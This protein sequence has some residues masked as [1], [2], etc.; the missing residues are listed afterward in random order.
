MKNSCVSASLFVLVITALTPLKAFSQGPPINT[1]TAIITGLEGAA[2]RSF[3]KSIKKSGDLPGG[4]TGRVTAIAVPLVV[5]YE[6]FTN[7]LIF[8]GIFPYFDKSRK[9]DK[10]GVTERQK[11]TGFGDASLSLKYLVFQRDAL[12]ETKRATVVG[13]IKLPTGNDDK[14]GLPRPFQLGSGSFDYHLG[15]TF[16]WVKGRGSVNADFLYTFKTEAGGFRFGDTMKYDLALGFR[17]LPVVYRTYPA[18]QLNIYLEFNGLYARRND[19]NGASVQD[20]G[21]NTV[22]ISPGIQFIPGRTLI[23]EASLQL[24]LIE[25]LNG[26]QLETDYTFLAGF[27][28][29]IY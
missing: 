5:P 3:V 18:K 17:L 9:T 25:D 21:G 8:V 26:T 4:G 29:L 20:S 7:K 10:A 14:K 11:T 6:I 27:R 22:L 2:V 15:S 16:T 28:W 12:K 23:F 24:P 1:D 13:G 19:V